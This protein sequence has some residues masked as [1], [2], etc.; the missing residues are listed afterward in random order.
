MGNRDNKA[1]KDKT[2]KELPEH[3]VFEYD[4][5]DGWD[6]DCKIYKTIATKEYEDDEDIPV[7]FALDAKGLVNLGRQYQIFIRLF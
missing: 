1:F 7:G 5:G 4:T 2:I 6:F 3:F